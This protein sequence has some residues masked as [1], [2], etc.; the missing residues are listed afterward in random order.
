[1]KYLLSMSIAEYD[2]K[3]TQLSQYTLHLIPTKK[4][5][6]KRFIDR[7]VRLLFRVV[8]LQI[9][10]FPSYATLVDCY[11]MLEMKDMEVCASQ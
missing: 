6:I 8:A 11:R 9:I 5:K 3:L 10:F 2:I 1:M 4:M 7:L